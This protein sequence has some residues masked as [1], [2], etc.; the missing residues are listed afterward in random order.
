[1][2][3][4][5]SEQIRCAADAT[6]V[7]MQRDFLSGASAET[8]IVVLLDLIELGALD[9]WIEDQPDPKAESARGGPSSNQRGVDEGLTRRRHRHVHRPCR[10]LLRPGSIPL[11]ASATHKKSSLSN[12]SRSDAVGRALKDW[13]QE[14]IALRKQR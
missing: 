4:K 1:M 10:L 2:P 9:L 7:T 6:V 8:P 5:S 11:S 14:L 3:G 13:L 12:V